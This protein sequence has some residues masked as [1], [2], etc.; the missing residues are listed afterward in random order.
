MPVCNISI[1]RKYSKVPIPGAV[2]SA[3]QNRNVPS[4]FLLLSTYLP[5]GDHHQYA[6]TIITFAVHNDEVFLLIF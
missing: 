6:K 2:F 1:E 3:F 4:V 5:H